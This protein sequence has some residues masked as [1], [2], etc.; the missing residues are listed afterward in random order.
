MSTKSRRRSSSIEG[1]RSPG[2][3]AQ[4][5][6]QAHV[7]SK[8]YGT[9]LLKGLQM[10]RCFTSSE[11]ER[12]ITELADALGL[13]KSTVLRIARSLE[14]EGFL[15]RVPAS[16]RYRLGLVLWSLGNL[17]FERSRGL[18]EL[19]HPY[20]ND[21]VDQ[22]RE[23]AQTVIL[24]GLECVRLDKVEAPQAVR[25]YMSEGGRF[26]A[27][28]SAAGQV[29]LAHQPGAVTTS[30]VKRGLQAYTP[31]TI[32]RSAELE[33]RLANVRCQGYAVSAGEYRGDV[34]GFG[35]PVRDGTGAVIGA[36]GIV[37]PMSRFPTGTRARHIAQLLIEATTRLSRDLGYIAERLPRDRLNA[38]R[39][40]YG[41]RLAR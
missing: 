16:G 26:P 3:H 28:V 20:L 18:A 23:S 6:L 27:Y 12:G 34:G 17:A 5:R 4:R 33:R 40:G 14:A 31:R 13:A 21:L 30:I 22:T 10:L 11:Y 39:N 37:I 35:A 41:R 38:P 24:D 32:T 7:D 19:G 25:A 29:L 36:L 9:S 1:A 8:M 15:H 2:D